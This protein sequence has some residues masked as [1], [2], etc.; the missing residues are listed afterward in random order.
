MD[1]MRLVLLCLVMTLAACGGEGGEKET[2]AEEPK[3][4]EPEVAAV[5]GEK[6]FRTY[7]VDLSWHRWEDGAQRCQGPGSRH[8]LP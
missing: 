3:A 7:C 2:T 4:A 5:D 8:H 1:Y 6:V